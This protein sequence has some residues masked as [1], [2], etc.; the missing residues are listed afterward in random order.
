MNNLN[1]NIANRK[2]G[3]GL[4]PYI[5]AEVSGNH[6][7]KIENAKS[8]IKIAKSAG[9][10]AAKL[11]T[12]TADSITIN[13]NKPEFTL[14]TGT[15][16]G[17]HIYEVYSQAST[18]I[19]WLPELITF[20]QSIGITVFTSVFDKSDVPTIAQLGV[21]AFKIASNE[22]TDWPLIEAVAKT[23]LP[24]IISTGTASKDDIADTIGFI[25]KLGMRDQLVMLH[26][27]SAYP[28]P[29]KDS[30]LNTMIDIS[31]SFGVITGLSDHTLG[32]STSIAATALG[33]AVIEKHITLDRNDK[34]PDSSFSLEP[35]ELTELCQNVK[36]AW[37]SLGTICYG[38]DTDLNKK[39]IF[40]RQLW[41]T[42][43]ILKGQEFTWDNIRSLRAP[44]KSEGLSPKNFTAVIGK[45]A[46]KTIDENQPLI[47]DF[48]Q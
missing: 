29:V 28:A 45:K 10:D 47:W 44:S 35:K 48:I 21:P 39:G 4:M 14:K 32:I 2:I 30:N 42:K 9:A 31:K 18:P 19:E 20:G 37:H 8:L 1:L 36:S 3:R 34:G 5:I 40:T 11:Q 26:C 17:K 16:A 41:S 6:N 24:M 38:G 7:G 15:W 27:V 22:L 13:S 23:R 43:K 46:S 12:Y 33:A 25:T